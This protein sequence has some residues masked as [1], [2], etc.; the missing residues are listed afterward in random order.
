MPFT[1]N[2]H[3]TIK[4]LFPV[5][6]PSPSPTSVQNSPPK[7]PFKQHFQI[8]RIINCRKTKIL[9]NPFTIPKFHSQSFTIKVI[10]S[11]KLKRC[12][13]PKM[14]FRNKTK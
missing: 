8:N 6:N 11:T 4:N 7:D 12:L 3:P 13:L 2:F 14:A 5:M 9:P 1:D 10:N